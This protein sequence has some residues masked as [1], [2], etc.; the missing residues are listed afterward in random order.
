MISMLIYLYAGQQII[1]LPDGRLQLLSMPQSAQAASSQATMTATTPPSTS[2]PVP[3]APTTTMIATPKVISSLA[4]PKAQLTIR[5]QGT[6]SGTIIVSPQTAGSV[7]T[8]SLAAPSVLQA[9]SNPS[10]PAINLMSKSKDGGGFVATV[11]KGGQPTTVALTPKMLSSLTSLSSPQSAQGIRTVAVSTVGGTQLRTIS[12]PKQPQIATL[13][14]GM[15]VTNPG[16]VSMTSPMKVS[17]MPQM[18]SASGLQRIL[19][20]RAGNCHSTFLIA[21]FSSVE[22]A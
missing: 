20:T 10:T 2:T 13:G 21:E 22:I 16:A 4:P 14:P 18:V 11:M 6:P 17:S 15:T 5:P 19:T 1:R 3:A 12:I 8:T 9:Q 7:A